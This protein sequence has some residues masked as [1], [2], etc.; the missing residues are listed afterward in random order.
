MVDRDEV[1]DR[2]RLP[3]EGV[4]GIDYWLS[5]HSIWGA[6]FR[7]VQEFRLRLYQESVCETIFAY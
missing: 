6:I 5:L 2:V 4:R 1:V 7:K 3:N